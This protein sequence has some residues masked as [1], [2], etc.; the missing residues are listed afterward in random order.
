VV[1]TL[2]HEAGVADP[3]LR[4]G[5]CD[6]RISPASTFKVAIGLMGFDAGI[7]T[8]PDEPE[9]PFRD[10]YADWNP[11]WKQATTPESWMRDSVVWFSQRATEELGEE[12]FGAYVDAFDYGNRDVSGDKGK[13]NGLTNA[14]LS[15]SLQI[16]PA[17]QVAF[18]TRMN[19]GG[20]PVS[21]SAVERTKELMDSG[22][23]PGGWRV[24]GK[25]GAGMPFGPGGAL[26]R[27]QP[28]GWY[29]GWAERDGRRVVFAR[30]IRFGERPPDSPGAIAR[31]GLLELL[32]AP[33]GLP[34]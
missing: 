6:E 15:S 20:L 23:R 26:L 34:D 17:E 27:N 10:G 33:G 12:R 24:Y 32:S 13:G 8:G 30:L 4:E 9:L 25:T 3:L 7:F 2:V 29:V 5:D 31:D 28:F 22:K 14:W 11:K 16:S 1:C 19:A 21:A 18:L